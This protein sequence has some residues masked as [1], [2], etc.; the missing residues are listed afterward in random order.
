MAPSTPPLSSEQEQDVRSQQSVHSPPVRVQTI[1]ESSDIMCTLTH[2]RKHGHFLMANLV[3]V[4]AAKLGSNSI[5]DSPCYHC[6]SLDTSPKVVKFE[7]SVIWSTALFVYQHIVSVLITCV[8]S[9]RL[10]CLSF[11]QCLLN[12][13]KQSKAPER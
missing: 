6:G 9:F 7:T 1:L 13:S 2:T 3:N 8:Y 12:H 11:V 5:T 4:K 10:L